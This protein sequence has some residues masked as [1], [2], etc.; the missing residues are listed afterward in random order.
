M[1]YETSSSDQ[2]LD[3]EG[4][5]F[6]RPGEGLQLVS[7]TPSK[8]HDQGEQVKAHQE[9][10]CSVGRQSGQH[11]R[12]APLITSGGISGRPFLLGNILDIANQFI[13]RNVGRRVLN[14]KDRVRDV[15]SS[16][17]GN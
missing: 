7:G 2:R 15:V 5:S 10:E 12:K 4:N 6:L 1:P 3:K 17:R 13:M 8:D 14:S 16:S 9:A 11:A